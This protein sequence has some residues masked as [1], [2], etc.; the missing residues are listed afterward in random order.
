MLFDMFYVKYEVDKGD[1]EKSID[2]VTRKAEKARK[3]TEDAGSK[4]VKGI[5]TTADE[6]GASTDKAGAS[7]DRYHQKLERIK[8]AA[9]QVKGI[10]GQIGDVGTLIKTGGV[11][12]SM[13]AGS[14]LVDNAMAGA[15][16]KR[17]AGG[18]GAGAVEGAVGG[19][20]AGGAMTRGMALLGG[21]VA[22]I[23]AA[24]AAVAAA[25]VWGVKAGHEIAGAAQEKYGSTKKDAWA[26]GMSTQSLLRHQISGEKLGISREESLRG[27]A[28]LNEKIKE[29]AL[30]RAQP[31]GG[32]DMKTGID[33]NP[34]SRLLRARGIKI[35]KGKHLESMDQIWKV[36]VEDLRTVAQKQGTNYALARA[37]QQYGLDFS[38]AS[39]IIE[40][41]SAQVQNMT[42]G[43][44]AQAIQETILAQVTKDYT[45][46]QGNLK[47][48]QEKTAAQIQTKVVPGMVSWTKET[49]ALEKNM[50]P[51]YALMGDLKRLMI[52]MA[53]GC[54]RL[55]NETIEGII[56]LAGKLKDIPDMLNNVGNNMAESVNNSV[57]DARGNLPSW[58]G[59]LTPEEVAAEKAKNAEQ[60]KAGAAEIQKGKEAA[61]KSKA[62][63]KEKS[64]QQEIASTFADGLAAY[65]KK[66][67]KASKED[68]EKMRK[69]YDEDVRAGGVSDTDDTV[70]I[71][72]ELEKLNGTSK[73]G[74]QANDAQFQVE[75]E[76]LSQIVTNTSVGLEQAIAMWAGGLGRAGGIGVTDGGTQGQSRADFEKR[77]KA[78]RFTPDPAMMKMG[79][80]LSLNAQHNAGAM[81]MAN[82]AAA[83]GVRMSE[84]NRVGA[85]GNTQGSSLSMGDIN[86]NL[87][88]DD[89]KSFAQQM[90][91]Y[92]GDTFNDMNKRI[93]NTFDSVFKA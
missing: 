85:S 54:L 81:S 31:M 3:A 90:G 37:T 11:W 14:R 69:G 29:V 33:T 75:K 2:T 30:H 4:G 76:K 47:V 15:A 59:G 57:A 78:I 43:I 53:T 68:I 72:A 77:S 93:A 82:D 71:V 10:L 92:V 87:R 73:E 63:S 50:R 5:K 19:M 62:E 66:H 65:E 42:Q 22:L 18:G 40:A 74:L 80:Q 86:V 83:K 20:S 8:A 49:T 34:M 9:M 64:T 41:T 26:A 91:G 45:Q 24:V 67:G 84:A 36:I 58:M 89:P 28:S 25:G 61:A 6:V 17:A 88:A 23:A 21:P 55:V 16:A 44:A 48:E 1:A 56:N 32:V 46:E 13:S 51:V 60:K 7:A 39:K 79:Q 27:M 38:Q 52:D 70:L 12:G 35:Q